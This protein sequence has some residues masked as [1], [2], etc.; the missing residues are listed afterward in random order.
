MSNMEYFGLISTVLGGILM[1]GTASLN[2]VSVT[3]KIVFIYWRFNG[4][5]G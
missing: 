1:I 2:K 3:L 4:Y 5:F